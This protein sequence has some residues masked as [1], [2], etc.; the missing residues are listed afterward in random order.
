M[1]PDALAGDVLEGRE[2]IFD[3]IL[4]LDGDSIRGELIELQQRA[5]S[6]LVVADILV[7]VLR[8]V[9]DLWEQGRL[10]V[11]HEHHASTIIRSVIG[12]FRRPALRDEDCPTVVLCCPPGE[13]HDLPGHLFSLML[14]ERGVAPL[15]LG[16]D[17]PWKA[18]VA[19]VRATSASACVL[20]GMRPNRLRWRGTVL[21]QIAA[22]TTL[23]VAGPL[24]E[25]ELPDGVRTLADEWRNA[26]AVVAQTALR[27]TGVMAEVALGTESPSG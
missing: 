1:S 8:R 16:A 4:G 15:V 21:T 13:L 3:A 10:G 2:R 6:D 17:T 11:L 25:G 18:L 9:G 14:L 7:P 19:A 5:G 22:S 12:Q 26:A 23:F 24:A 20:S 27:P